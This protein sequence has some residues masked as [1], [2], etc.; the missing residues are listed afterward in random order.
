[1][2]RTTSDGGVGSGIFRA[3]VRSARVRA[4]HSTIGAAGPFPGGGRLAPGEP[5]WTDASITRRRAAP[6]HADGLGQPPL[7]PSELPRP[8]TA[9]AWFHRGAVFAV[10]SPMFRVSGTEGDNA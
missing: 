1:M 7:P 3:A 10:Q 5:T 8:G 6:A 9:P 4:G 2:V